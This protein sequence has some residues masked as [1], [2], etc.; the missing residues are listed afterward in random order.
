MLFYCSKKVA[1]YALLVCKIFGPKIRSC[2]IFDK[3]QVCLGPKSSADW[4]KNRRDR[5]LCTQGAHSERGTGTHT[6]NLGVQ[7]L[8]FWATLGIASRSPF[9][10]FA[11]GATTDELY[12]PAQVFTQISI[13]FHLQNLDQALTSKSQP[14]ISILT[15]HQ[16]L[17]QT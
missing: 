15:K 16:N 7:F 4:S 14:N 11:I 17:V 2:K 1:L 13:K 6:A 3:F 5:G 10:I 12:V 8:C 9:E